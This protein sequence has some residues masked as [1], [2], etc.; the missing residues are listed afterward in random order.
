MFNWMKGR[1]NCWGPIAIN[2][3]WI[4]HQKEI[5]TASPGGFFKNVTWDLLFS[6]GRWG[7]YLRRI[8]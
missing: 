8:L 1:I 7:L 3:T 5:V 4:K 6:I 2:H